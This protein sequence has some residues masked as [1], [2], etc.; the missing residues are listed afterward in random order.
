[1]QRRQRLRHASDFALLRREGRRYHHP[2][3][4]LV[5]RANGGAESRFG[6]SAVVIVGA[7]PAYFSYLEEP[8]REVVGPNW[9]RDTIN[10]LLVY[11]RP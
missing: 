5:V 10:D 2:L 4:V 7:E 1:M 3:L 11:R 8:L 6:F 9:S